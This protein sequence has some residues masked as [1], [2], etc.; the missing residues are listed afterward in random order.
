MFENGGP[1]QVDTAKIQVGESV[2]WQWVEGSHTITSG[3]GSADPNAGALFNQPSDSGHLQFMFTFNSIG[4]FP[5]FCQ[6]HEL[7]NMRGIVVVSAATGVEPAPVTRALGFTRDPAPNPTRTGLTF[8]Y[9]M[10]ESGRARAEVFD[11][12]GRRVAVLVDQVLPP[13]AHSGSWDGR[14]PTGLADTGIYF[15]R[16]VL[17]GY[18]QS[19][20]IVIRR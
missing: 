15:V 3:T 6:F 13:G 14:T 12:T 16:L 20:S 9:A 7:Q 4:T 5:F 1:S 19:R 18:D 10:R 2:L 8:Q 17:P 11:A